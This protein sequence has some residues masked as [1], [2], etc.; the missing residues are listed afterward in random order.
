MGLSDPLV[1]GISTRTS[2]PR[3]TASPKAAMA[4]GSGMK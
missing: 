4:S 1:D 2:T 3:F